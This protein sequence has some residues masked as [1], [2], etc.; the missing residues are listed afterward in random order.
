MKRTG[1]VNHL[2]SLALW[3][4]SPLSDYVTGQVYTVDGAVVKSIL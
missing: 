2:A 4:L 1:N 3:L